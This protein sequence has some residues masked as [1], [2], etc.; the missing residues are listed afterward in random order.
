MTRGAGHDG[1]DH[2]G[3]QGLPDGQVVP[4]IGRPRGQQLGHGIPGRSHRTGCPSGQR[5]EQRVVRGDGG[6]V[7]EIAERQHVESRTPETALTRDSSSTADRGMRWVA[8][9]GSS[10]NP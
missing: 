2:R 9:H 1:L 5:V 4:R 7:D 3:P 8:A 10:W 6:Q